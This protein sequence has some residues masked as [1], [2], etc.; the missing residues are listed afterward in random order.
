MKNRKFKEYSPFLCTKINL[1]TALIVFILFICSKLFMEKFR[2]DALA[3]VN[4]LDNGT[5]AMM[6][7]VLVGGLVG[8][9]WIS[10][11]V[12]LTL[13]IPLFS[14]FNDNLKSLVGIVICNFGIA[15]FLFLNFTLQLALYYFSTVLVGAYFSMYFRYKKG[16][17][18]K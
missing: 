8:I 18:T 13:I 7:I 4:D 16:V 9:L 11:S 10:C 15:Y 17:L 5:G 2:R 1:F 6:G 3:S 12:L 14:D